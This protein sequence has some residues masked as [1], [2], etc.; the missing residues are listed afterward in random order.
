MPPYI[1]GFV[2]KASRVKWER[3]TSISTIQIMPVIAIAVLLRKYLIRGLT[4][5]IAK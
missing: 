3:I 2:V 5:G 1:G 4:L